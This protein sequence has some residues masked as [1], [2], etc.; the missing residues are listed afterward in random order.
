MGIAAIRIQT[1][2]GVG[3]KGRPKWL[4][5]PEGAIVTATDVGPPFSVRA[6]PD[7]LAKVP[8]GSE[9]ISQAYVPFGSSNVSEPV[10]DREVPLMRTVQEVPMGSPD[11]KNVTGNLPQ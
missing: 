9:V 6:P 5:R 4:A 3:A 11:S 2:S 8:F 1:Q 10:P 7:G